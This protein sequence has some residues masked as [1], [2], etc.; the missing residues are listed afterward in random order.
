MLYQKKK[1]KL[2]EETQKRKQEVKDEFE[3]MLKNE[4]YG[5]DPYQE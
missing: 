4:L 5:Y 3:E 2:K 1:E